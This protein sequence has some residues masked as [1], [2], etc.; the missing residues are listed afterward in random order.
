M[1]NNRIITFDG[2]RGIAVLMVMLLHAH[3]Q[4]G[5]GGAIGVDIFFVLSGFLITQNLLDDYVSNGNISMKKFWLKRFFRLFPPF[6]VLLISIFILSFYIED[7]KLKNAVLI[8]IRDSFLYLSNFSWFWSD[9]NDN[10]ILGHTWSL[11]VEQQF[12][13]VWPLFLYGIIRFVQ[14]KWVFVML[15]IVF[16]SLSFFKHSRYSSEIFKSIYFESIFIGCMFSIAV[17]NRWITN[18][19]HSFLAFLSFV[20][21]CVV[22]LFGFDFFKYFSLTGYVFLLVPLA[23]ILI[24]INCMSLD[25]SWINNILSFK[26]LVYIGSISYGLYL[27][28]IPV[29]RLFKWYSNSPPYIS[30]IL[31]FILTFIIASLSYFLLEKKML[32]IS[33]NIMNKLYK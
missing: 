7:V 9:H 6:F 21:I 12:Y 33:R 4:L 28:H 14:K 22:G 11:S 13:I 32:M 5:K 19:R 20:L 1:T 23:V 31:K 16:L 26:P 8:E 10:R 30:F 27:W 17:W 2:I 3:F 15:L 18:Y 25:N 24:L 29:F